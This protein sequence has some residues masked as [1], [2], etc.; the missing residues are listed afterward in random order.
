VNDL[1]ASTSTGDIDYYGNTVFGSSLNP[2]TASTHGV[3]TL[4]FPLAAAVL[5]PMAIR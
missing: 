1:A 2:A 5:A 4:T 3:V